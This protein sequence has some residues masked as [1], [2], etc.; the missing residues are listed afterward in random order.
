MDPNV[1]P[2]VDIFF[3]DETYPDEEGKGRLQCKNDAKRIGITQLYYYCFI[4]SAPDQVYRVTN[5]SYIHLTTL[6][7]YTQRATCYMKEVKNPACL[8]PAGYMGAY[9]QYHDYTKC[10]VNITQ[11]ALYKGCKDEYPDSDYYLYSIQGFDPC[12]HFDFTKKQEIKFKLNC[13]PLT[14]DGVV[15]EAGHVEKLGF[16]Y[17]DII[18]QEKPKVK[19]EYAAFNNKTNLKVNK[20]DYLLFSFDF[21]DWKYLTNVQQF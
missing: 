2:D 16:D 14:E 20:D 9:C 18:K 17:V 19:F 1:Q 5:Q 10:Y 8:C 13:L 21:R 11:P 6:P 12:H 3:T 4:N 15:K 7:F